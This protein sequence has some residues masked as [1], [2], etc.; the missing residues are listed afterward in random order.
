MISPSPV[1]G[2]I[3]AGLALAEGLDEDA[4]HVDAGEVE[5]FGRLSGPDG[6]ADF[7]ENV[8]EVGNVVGLEASAEV[9]GSGGI[10]NALSANGVEKSFVIAAKFDVLEA[11][12]IA[13]N[14]VREVEYVVRFMI[15]EM[16]LEQMKPGVNCVDQADALGEQMKCADAAMRDGLDAS[17]ELV[18][19]IASGE[20]RHSRVEFTFLFEPPF[21]SAL[22]KLPEAS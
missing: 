1:V 9:A 8:D 18:M 17:A 10:G 16:E 22:A 6:F 11:I 14:I 20:G 12:A 7:V 15:G 19:D 3:H 2:D 21:D 5:E 4:I 13:K